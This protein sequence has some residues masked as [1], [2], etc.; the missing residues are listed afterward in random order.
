MV[1][2]LV[3]DTI[4]RTREIQMT[5]NEVELIKGPHSEAQSQLIRE[6]LVRVEAAPVTFGAWT[7]TSFNTEDGVEIL[8]IS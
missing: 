2:V 6:V 4:M 7:G 1:K 5:E 8:E 3:T